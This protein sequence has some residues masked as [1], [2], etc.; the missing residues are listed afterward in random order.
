M[1]KINTNREIKPCPFCGSKARLESHGSSHGFCIYVACQ[2]E[3]ECYVRPTTDGGWVRDYD[4]DIV[5]TKNII[6]D[7]WNRRVG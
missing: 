3:N 1:S 4:G 2:A 6:I 5:K 7:R